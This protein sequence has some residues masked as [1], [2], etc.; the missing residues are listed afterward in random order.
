MDLQRLER[1]QFAAE[2]RRK[3]TLLSDE[4]IADVCEALLELT[5]EGTITL[6]LHHDVMRNVID[7]DAA[8]VNAMTR[9]LAEARADVGLLMEYV[10]DA[11][12]AAQQLGRYQGEPLA[13][14]LQRLGVEGLP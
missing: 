9:E 11:K 1:A 4:A 5:E 6:E 2:L 7:A 3:G 13:E 12:K 14:F 8:R 10:D